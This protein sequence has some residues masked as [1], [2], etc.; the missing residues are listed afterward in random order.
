MPELSFEFAMLIF[1]LFYQLLD[2]PLPK[3]EKL[4][5]MMLP[6]LLTVKKSKCSSALK[7]P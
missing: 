4:A 5:T 1:T 3:C 2:A 6:L 7:Y